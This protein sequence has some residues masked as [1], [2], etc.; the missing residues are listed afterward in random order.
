MQRA[1]KSRADSKEFYRKG[2]QLLNDRNVSFLIGG[3]HAM[4][5]YTG[6]ERETKDF[7]L[8]VRAQDIEEVLQIFQDEGYRVERSFPHWLAKVFAGEYL[9]D[10]IYR[11]GNG[12]C[13]VDDSWL[14]RSQ[15]REVFGVTARVTAP[16][17]LIWMK[18]YIMER[19]RYDGADIA[20]LLLSCADRIDW[21]HLLL[22]FGDDWRVL[23][24][25]LV[26][27][28]FIY[29]SERHRIP[30]AVLEQLC[31]KL[32]KEQIAPETDRVCRGTLLSR[33]QYLIDVQER[34]FRDARLDAR[35]QLTENDVRFWTA[36]IPAE[37]GMPVSQPGQE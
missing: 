37:A 23:L 28:G 26:L 12:L 4:A 10:L 25:Q 14:D 3:A 21:K 5:L 24:T 27:F 34:G 36:N 9:I 18:A 1:D 17:E 33:A 13:E 8:Y 2:L 31:G 11:A 15:V 19:E 6:I 30:A 20:H 16:E 7:D 32:S 22:R 35:C 29:P